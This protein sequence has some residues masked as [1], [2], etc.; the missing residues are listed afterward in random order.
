MITQHILRNLRYT[1]DTAAPADTTFGPLFEVETSVYKGAFDYLID[2]PERH[3]ALTSICRTPTQ[4]SIIVS[5]PKVMHLGLPLPPMLHHI[6]TLKEPSGSTSD[7][8]FKR[9]KCM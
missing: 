9:V 3:T 2:I 1:Q 7:R 5:H 8:Y 4:L 6:S